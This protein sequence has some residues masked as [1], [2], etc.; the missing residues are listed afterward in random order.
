MICAL[1]RIAALQRMQHGHRRFAF[2]Q[3]AGDGLAQHFFRGRQ[4]EHVID[5]L[6]GHAE[7]ASVLGQAMLIGVAGAGKNSAQLHADREQERRLAMNQF[8]MLVERDGFAQPFDLQQLAFDHRLR[9]VDQG[10]EHL[11]ISF[12]DGDLEGLH[13][14]PVAGEHALGVAPLGVGRRTS[15][16]RLRFVDDVVVNQRRGVNDLD[17]GAQ[18]D[19]A[20]AGVVH[21]LAGEQQQGGAKAFAAAGAKVFADLR[22]C[23]H[24]GNRVA[25]ELA[26]D[27]GEVVVQQVENF[28]GGAGYGDSNNISPSFSWTR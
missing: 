4:V 21:Q 3:I 14:E 2:A 25:A 11:E 8:E 19:G 28:L 22:N 10:I 20:L 26:L 5:D 23:P 6:E 15:A 27:G 12:L 17:H 7:I 9:Q 24:A 16:A 13:V 18:L 1:R